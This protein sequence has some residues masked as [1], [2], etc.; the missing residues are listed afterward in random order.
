MQTVGQPACLLYGI[1]P[2]A[3]RFVVLAPYDVSPHGI[4][5]LPTRDDRAQR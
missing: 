5:H 1:S 3:S 2:R 4:E